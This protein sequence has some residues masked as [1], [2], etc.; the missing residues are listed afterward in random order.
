VQGSD[1]ETAP[2]RGS[3]GYPVVD[4]VAFLSELA[5][6]ATLGVAGWRLGGGGLISISLAVLYP[7]LAVLIWS[8][9]LAPRAAHRLGDPGRLIVQIVVFLATGVASAI[10][11]R[12][13]WGI[14]LAT[15]GVAAFVAARLL[16]DKAEARGRRSGG[17]VLVVEGVV[18][19]ADGRE[20]MQWE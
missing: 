2:R 7:A 14:L 3:V 9:W 18:D 20:A 5:M 19:D 12:L 4:M 13:V 10:A 15:V 1:G 8:V 11:G 6:F 17:V 16:N